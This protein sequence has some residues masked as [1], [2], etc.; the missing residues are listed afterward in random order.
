LRLMDFIDFEGV[1]IVGRGK[2]FK[3]KI[4]RII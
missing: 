2:E 3:K 4:K 1:K